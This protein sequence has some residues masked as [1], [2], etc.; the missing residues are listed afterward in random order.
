MKKEKRVQQSHTVNV[1]NKLST[2]SDESF[3]LD[4][5]QRV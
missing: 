4:I 2:F 5:V 1:E 3:Q